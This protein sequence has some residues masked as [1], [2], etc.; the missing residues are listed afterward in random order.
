MRST[1]SITTSVVIVAACL[2]ASLVLPPAVLSA[3]Q[4][5]DSTARAQRR[6]LDSLAAVVR[7][8]QAQ[9]DSTTRSTAAAQSSQPGRAP[10]V[11]MN[12]SFV[13][14][15]DFGWSTEPKVT[16]LQRGDHDPS[17]RGFT[18]PNAELSLDGAV[19]PY[20]KAFANIVYKLDPVGETGIELEEVFFLTTSLPWNLQLKGGQFNVEF[21]RENPQHPHAWGF[22]DQPLVL[23]RMFGPDGLRSQGLRL[24]WLAPTS[25]FT[26]AMVTVAN[27]AGETASSFRN[28]E[29][30]DIHGGIPLE[31]DVSRLSDLLIVP[32]LSSSFDVTDNSTV[33]VG[34]SAALGPNNSGPSASSQV[35]GADIYYKWKAPSARQGFPFVSV[36]AEALARRYD[37]AERVAAESSLPLPA[38]TLRDRGY[39]AQLLWGI[40]PMTV[41]GL[42]GE[43]VTGDDASFQSELR[44]NR[45]R[46]SPNITWYPTEFSKFR[47]Q[48]NYDH[49]AD[50]GVD[51]SVWMQFEFLLGAHAAHKF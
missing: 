30:V 48:Y 13:G 1:K 45:Y 9:V 37:A 3:Q 5:S 26:E 40:R 20:F 14:L 34:A 8:L 12:T 4:A 36:Q 16:T 27:S 49:R 46:V 21:G 51:H 11:Y 22:A 23:N 47:V 31:R 32:R 43:A 25:H 28:E 33:V 15:A 38:E 44:S 41:A 17:V 10:G 42:R 29:S 50:I 39:T 35:Y 7:A 6:A 24:S 18:I 19:D 2:G